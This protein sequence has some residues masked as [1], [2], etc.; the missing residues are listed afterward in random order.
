MI[1]RMTI[2]GRRFGRVTCSTCCHLVAPSTAAASYWVVSMPVI[3]ARYSTEEYPMFFHRLQIV[4][5][6]GHQVVSW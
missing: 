1:S 5:I 3:P 6:S 4:R 2:M